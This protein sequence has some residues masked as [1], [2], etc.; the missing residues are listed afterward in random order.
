MS[1][2]TTLYGRDH[3]LMTTK[4]RRRPDH[5]SVSSRKFMKLYNTIYWGDRS[6]HLSFDTSSRSKPGY[7][8]GSV[9]RTC[10][11]APK[12]SKTSTLRTTRFEKVKDRSKFFKGS[13]VLLNVL[14]MPWRLWSISYALNSTHFLLFN[15]EWYS[16]RSLKAPRGNYS[17]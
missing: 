9:I 5:K 12:V 15:W 8:A 11:N 2:K 16:G 6:G 14:F 17:V 4:L 3:S 10:W 13:K 7:L 1:R